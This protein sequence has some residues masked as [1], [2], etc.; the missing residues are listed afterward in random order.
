MND[1]FKCYP[2]YASFFLEKGKL[3]TWGYGSIKL[4]Y[5]A[6]NDKQLS[7]R[8][9]ESLSPYTLIHASCGKDFTLGKVYPKLS[10]DN[11][12]LEIKYV[13]YGIS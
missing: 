2:I 3:Y 13:F 8:I 7:P 5:E 6:P 9:V 10:C 11:F 12:Y 4:G 1:G